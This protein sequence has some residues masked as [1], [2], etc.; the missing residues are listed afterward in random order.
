MPGEVGVKKVAVGTRGSQLALWQTQWV[1][2]RLQERHPGVT[3]ELVKIK[4]SGDKILNSPLSAIGDRGLFVKEIELALQKGEVDLAVHSMKD[5]PTV[6]A[7]GLIL[8]AVLERADPRDVLVSRRYRSLAELPEGAAVGTSS[9]RR[10]AQLSRHRPD[11]RFVPLRG[12]LDTR[13]RKLETQELAAIVLA[14][15]GLERL[16]WQEAIAEYLP[17]EVCLPAVGQGAIGIEIRAGD[18]LMARL[19]DCVDHPPTRAAVTAERAFLARLEG[20]CQIPIGALARAEG[21]VLHLAGVIASLDGSCLVRGEAA[22]S[23][24]EA[25]AIGQRLADELRR[26]GGEEILAQFR[27]KERSNAE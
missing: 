13:L 19:V 15:A 25:V 2:A 1:V 9:L 20:G 6:L 3:F 14:A 21:D 5:V 12:N 27:A 10:V 16:G 24:A 4:T 7:P 11:L 18:E 8:G 26:Q 22:G 17:P 23:P